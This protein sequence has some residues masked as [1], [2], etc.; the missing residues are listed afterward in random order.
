[1]NQ[2]IEGADVFAFT[3]VLVD[4]ITIT[5]VVYEFNYEIKFMN[6][7]MNDYKFVIKIATNGDMVFN[8]VHR[9]MD[10]KRVLVK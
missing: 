5:R 1:M 7:A 6:P 4:G 3:M 10:Y 9:V 8:E 2:L